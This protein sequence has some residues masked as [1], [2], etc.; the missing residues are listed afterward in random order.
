M[1]YSSR[2]VQK[3]SDISDGKDSFKPGLRIT[4][5]FDSWSERLS[6]LRFFIRSAIA[7]LLNKELEQIFYDEDVERITRNM[8]RVPRE[9]KPR[10]A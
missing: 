7:A 10:K 6:C 5:S 2:I 8:D 4:F 9:N 3:V 1:A